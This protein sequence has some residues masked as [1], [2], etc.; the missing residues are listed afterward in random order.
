MPVTIGEISN[1]VAVTGDG[2]VAQATGSVQ[3]AERRTA[4]QQA[5]HHL[6]EPRAAAAALSRRRARTTCEPRDR[7]PHHGGRDA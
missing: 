3:H 5:L 4:H 2:A 6:D 7:H 1:S